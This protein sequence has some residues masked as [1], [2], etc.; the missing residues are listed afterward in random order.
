MTNLQSEPEI[1][2]VAEHHPAASPGL[3]RLLFEGSSALGL[4]TL[5]ERGLGFAA[6]LA[7]ARIGGTHVFGAYSVAMTTANNIASYAGAGIGTTANRFSGEYPYGTPG[8]SGLLRTLA[9]VSLASAALAAA[10]LWLSAQPLAT[11]LLLNPSLTQLLRLAALSSGAIILFDCMRGLLIGQRRFVDLVALSIMFG[12]GLAIVLPLAASHGA[13]AMVMGQATIA[14][15]AVVICIAAA[16]KLGF[17]PPPQKLAAKQK[18]PGPG[19]IVRFGFV[20]L[21]GMVGVS[22]AGWWAASLVARADISLV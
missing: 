13:Y 6:N 11:H 7:A 4:S 19:T 3:R 16:R 12:G 21:A 14:L 18:G 5:I 1:A 15:L 2:A 20:Q 8:Y 17:A 10:A 9:I 22:A